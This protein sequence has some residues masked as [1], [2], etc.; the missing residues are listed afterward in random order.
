MDKNN[1]Y[2]LRANRSAVHIAHDR[3]L[4]V[5]AAL[6][7]ATK[8]IG[9]FENYANTKRNT[10]RNL[11]AYAEAVVARLDTLIEE[12]DKEGGNNK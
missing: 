4:E 11:I 7:D 1:I 10:V 5:E 12:A 6:S 2:A 9:T 3:L 8:A